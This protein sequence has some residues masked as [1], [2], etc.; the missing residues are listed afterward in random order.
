LKSKEKLDRRFRS[1]A[2]LETNL[3]FAEV[4][5][6]S[7]G[8]KGFDQEG[9]PIV[10]SNVAKAMR[11]K[12]FKKAKEPEWKRMLERIKREIVVEA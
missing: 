4:A 8:R 7:F 1:K 2:K 12:V 6:G 5:Y 3:V 10:A 11:D 9:K